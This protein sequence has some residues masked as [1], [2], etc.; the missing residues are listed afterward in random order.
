MAAR[1]KWKRF[2]SHSQSIT[3]EL[4]ESLA[5]KDRNGCWVWPGATQ[6]IGY[7]VLT[8]NGTQQL[9][10]RLTWQLWFGQIPKNLYV[11]HTCDVR[12][13]FNP[14]HLWLGTQQDNV[15]DMIAKGRKRTRGKGRN[16]I[17][18]RQP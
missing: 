2:R 7:G 3:K 14:L 12:R 13:C 10:H 17:P 18:L 15:R 4:L 11:L 8:L 6:T 16:Q 5:N 1:E 9:V